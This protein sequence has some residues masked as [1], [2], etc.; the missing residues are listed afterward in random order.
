MA[1]LRLT[2]EGIALQLRHDVIAGTHAKGH[3]GERG[4]LARIRRKA[5]NVFDL[6]V[7]FDEI[8]PARQNLA[9]AGDLDAGAGLKESFL[10]SFA[11]AGR[12]PIEPHGGFAFV[13][14]APDEFLV[15][16]GVRQIAE[17]SDVDADWF[18]G[19]AK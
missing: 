12:A 8:V 17:T 9:E 6:R 15:R 5:G 16:R 18:M 7:Q 13:A 3:D 10:V 19:S 1:A 11:K 4:I 2:S 14:V